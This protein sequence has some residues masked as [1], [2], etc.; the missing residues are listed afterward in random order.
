MQIQRR[1]KFNKIMKNKI[2]NNKRKS[3]Q[4]VSFYRWIALS[5]L[6]GIGLVALIAAGRS[7]RLEQQEH[8]KTRLERAVRLVQSRLNTAIQIPLNTVVSMQAF[9]L[10]SPTLP[11]FKSF[12][13][14][15]AQ[16]L[17]H[18]PAVTGFAFVDPQ[19][20]I[21]HF[22]PLAGNEKAIGLD[23]MS[24]PAA[25]YVESAI[26]QRRMTMN[27]PAITV[28]GQLSTIARI[29]LYRGDQLLG[30]VQGVID[31]DKTLQLVLEDL[32][33]DVHIYLEDGAGRR[34]WGPSQ[35]PAQARD[36]KIKV[37]DS[38]WE[39]KVWLDATDT[40]GRN[41]IIWLIW[42]VGS[43][44][45][46][47]LLFIVNRAFTESA[48]LTTAIQNKTA[49][50]AGSEARWRSLLEQVH[51]IGI[52]LDRA[53]SVNYV[54]PYFCK[55]T[56]YEKDE[57]LGKEWF[58]NFLPA[59]T[60]EELHAVYEKLQKGDM[61]SQ[62]LNPILT[63]SGHERV[64]SWFNARLVDDRGRF[65][66]IFS[67]GEDIT[68]RHEL[69][70][71]LDYLAY[72]DTLTG[73]PNRTLLL[74]RLSHAVKRAQRDNTLLALL[75]ID[76]DQFKNINDSLGHFAGD[77]LLQAAA[78]RF[79]RALRSADTVAR[80]GG[81]EFTVLLENI[82]HID[83]VEEI[84]SKILSE[85]TEPFEV[86]KNKLYISASIGVVMY[87]FGESQIEDLMRA[88]DTAM[89]HAKAAG[90]NCY[91]FYE[92]TMTTMAHNQLSIANNLH[93]ALAKEE[94]S[95]VFQPIVE[96]ETQQ[97][98]GFETL[99]RWED[100]ELG[101][102]SPA[103][104]IPVAEST[105]MIVN[106]GY[107]VL[108][109]ACR[110]YKSLETAVKTDI[111]LSVNVSGYQFRDKNFIDTFRTILSDEGMSPK[112]LIVEITESQLM[113]ETQVALQ[114]LHEL[115]D[116]GCRVSIDDFGT[117]YSS[118]SYLRIFPVDILKIDRSFIADITTDNNSFAL[119]KAIL[120]IAD[121]LQINVV[122]EGVET[123]EQLTI[124]QSL[125]LKMAQ[126]YYLGTP[127]ALAAI[128]STKDFDEVRG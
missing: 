37:G 28:Q 9:M 42:L 18:T 10:A 81:D 107:W 88:A 120:M 123:S 17:Q 112:K 82:K 75:I 44:L 55:V 73:L 60:F 27:P 67:I 13:Q 11:D 25:R 56:G 14:F 7:V 111:S 31:I 64:I 77:M 89:Y 128:V 97:T 101:S 113:E 58:T 20:I 69:E 1:V 98:I 93:D 117:G 72:H 119:L 71:R 2:N 46:V 35:Y 85:F 79:R 87:P 84:A 21:R 108:R 110:C 62:Y 90:R 114:V 39:A 34:F 5:L 29:P 52:G 78:Q 57:V 80:L 19:R 116:M 76:L 70:K 24:R 124:L 83:A 47:S 53:G 94:F 59:G 127:S 50:L 40:S 125:G 26:R 100:A 43:A 61:V 121:S 6:A 95:L 106:I 86:E 118:L 91:R 126:G 8:Q 68:A 122:A 99:L 15:A 63:K 23:L 105:G 36:L 102:I 33:T 103:D 4:P 115:R 54:N 65:D 41:S 66:G 22:Y 96:L 109:Q 92:A 12:D 45:L 49:Q 32:D 16:M 104:F 3:T 30:L 48:R 38:R 51:L 74:D